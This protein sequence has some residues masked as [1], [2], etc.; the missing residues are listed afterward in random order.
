[1]IIIVHGLVVQFATFV[2]VITHLSI[3]YKGRYS[4][5]FDPEEPVRSGITSIESVN[6]LW[7]VFSTVTNGPLN[8]S[9]HT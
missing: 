3:D 2:I 7:P 6:R 1:M 5:D 4:D 8:P 9:I